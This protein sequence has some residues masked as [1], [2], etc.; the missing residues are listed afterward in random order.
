[1]DLSEV[2]KSALLS[3]DQ[4]KYKNH[5]LFFAGMPLSESKKFFL[6]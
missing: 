6:I 1:M 3:Y 4:Y 5:P 2:D